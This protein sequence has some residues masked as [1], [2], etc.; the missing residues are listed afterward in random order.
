MDPWGVTEGKNSMSCLWSWMFPMLVHRM[1]LGEERG[2]MEAPLDRLVPNG[3]YEDI[4]L[5]GERVEVG[6]ELEVGMDTG[7]VA[8]LGSHLHLAASRELLAAMGQSQCE[9]A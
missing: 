9:Q 7:V 1:Y 3:D 5:D 6:G 4:E 2:V 8:A